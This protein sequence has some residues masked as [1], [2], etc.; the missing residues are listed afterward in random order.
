MQGNLPQ[1][2]YFTA[3]NINLQYRYI[4][5]RSNFSIVLCIET[6]KLYYGLMPMLQIIP[7]IFASVVFDFSDCGVK[8]L[9]DPGKQL[10]ADFKLFNLN[11]YRP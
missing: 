3:K 7:E 6:Q 10:W 8:Y 9:V 2:Y 4:V 1:F 5:A 11:I